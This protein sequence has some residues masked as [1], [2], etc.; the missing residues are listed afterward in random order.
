MFKSKHQFISN[1][2]VVTGLYL[3]NTCLIFS[4]FTK[5]PQNGKVL[6]GSDFSLFQVKSKQ[7]SQ[8]RDI[9]N[10]FAPEW[11][12]RGQRFDPAYLHQSNIIRTFS[13]SGTGSDLLFTWTIS[14]RK[15]SGP[16][17]Y[18]GGRKI[19]YYCVS[20]WR[21]HSS[22]AACPSSLAKYECICGSRHRASVSITKS[23]TTICPSSVLFGSAVVTVAT[24]FTRFSR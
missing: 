1:Y 19:M 10:N 20:C 6:K 8:N 14:A 17:R 12:S 3:S 23:G 22:N 13:P 5:T 9:V 7:L 16:C 24:S 21:F 4:D 18:D 15:E 2:S 11:H